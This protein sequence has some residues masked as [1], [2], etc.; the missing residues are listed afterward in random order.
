MQGEMWRSGQE[1][2]R[3]V[4]N[5]LY[6]LDWSQSRV[7]LVLHMCALVC[8]RKDLL[9]FMK[10]LRSVKTSLRGRRSR[11]CVDMPSALSVCWHLVPSL[12]TV[13]P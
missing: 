13:L 5:T 11:L 3:G 1:K 4:Y 12:H 6:T 8:S 2:T 7:F 10:D 9:S